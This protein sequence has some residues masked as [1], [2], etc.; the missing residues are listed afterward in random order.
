VFFLFLVA[1]INHVFLTTT[2]NFVYCLSL[3]LK[4][5]LGVVSTWGLFLSIQ[6]FWVDEPGFGD[7]F[8]VSKLR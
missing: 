4:Q 5:F 7:I 1:L 8:I 2:P 3:E 6:T